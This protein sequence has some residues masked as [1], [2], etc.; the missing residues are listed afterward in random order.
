[1]RPADEIKEKVKRMNF[2]AD[3]KMRQVMLDDV[4]AAQNDNQKQNLS[5]SGWG[6]WR[7]IMRNKMTKFA[8]VAVI[9]IITVVG[10]SLIDSNQGVVWADVVEHIREFRPYICK[11]TVQREGG[12]AVSMQ[13]YKFSLSRW[14]E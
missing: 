9:I 11:Y 8:A 6:I 12:P 14:R 5:R 3:E 7:I 4:L 13:V 2:T 1:M 10:I